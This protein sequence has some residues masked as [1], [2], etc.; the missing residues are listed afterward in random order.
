[1]YSSTPLP[2][3]QWIW[4]RGTIYLL[5]S[6]AGFRYDFDM[7]ELPSKAPF[8]I[9]ADQSY[10]LHINGRYVCRGPVRGIQSNWHFDTVDIL[11]FLKNGHNWISIEAFNPGKSSFFYNHKDAAGLLCSADWDNG[12]QI[13]S[14]V[15][16]WQIFR[17]TAYNNNTAQLS[18]QMGQMEELDLRFDDRSWITEKNYTL[19][20]VMRGTRPTSRKQGS[21]PWTKLS[22]RTIPQLDESCRAPEKLTASGIGICAEHA[23]QAPGIIPCTTADFVD[24][25]LDTIQYDSCPIKTV[26]EKEQMSFTLPAAGKGKFSVAVIDLGATQWLPGVPLFE[27]GEHKAGTILD[28]F[29]NQYMPDGKI[30]Y[31]WDPSEGSQ[32]SLA[33]RVHLNGKTHKFELFQIM[34]VRHIVLVL[35]E[36]A[37]PVDMKLAWRSAVYPLEIKGHFSCSDSVLNAIYDISVHTQRVCALDAFVDTPWREQ[38]QWWGDARVQA[39][40][41]I[42]LSGDSRLLERGI[43]SIAEQKNQLGLTFANA[44]TSDCGPILPDFCLTWVITLHDYWFQTKDTELFK[45]QKSQAESIFNYFENIRG[46]RGLLKYDPRFWLF[47]DWSNLPKSNTPTFLN[48]WYIYAREKY[49]TLLEAAG[50]RSEAEKLNLAISSDKKLVKELLF[51]AEMHLFLPERNAEDKL[52]GAPSVHDQVLALL[53]NIAPEAADSMIEKVIRPCLLGNYS[54]GALPSSFW[55]T[56]LLD[57]AQEYGLRE[58]ALFYIKNNW[59]TMIPAG[60]TWENFPRPNPG[61]LSCAHA[62]SAHI[63]SHLPELVFGLKQLAPRWEDIELDY[64]PL[65][66]VEEAELTLPLPQGE[67]SLRYDGKNVHSQIPQGVHISSRHTR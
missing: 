28:V 46:P 19:P 50:F 35:R 21:L 30:S 18:G 12:T 56:Y 8:I 57:C 49:C 48:L 53:L 41:T 65:P 47:E 25:E 6:Y 62:W 23:L 51:D 9:T 5:N 15:N 38:S 32:V 37:S 17:N 67:L 4:P 22:P 3:A 43:N 55:A 61:E 11:Q 1:M 29:Y 26:T 24:F 34:G 16:D 7:T 58:E 63:I 27:I 64:Q 40:N 44:P 66:G 59:Q 45:K 60:T 10:K 54:A 31:A 39:K 42:F 52:S 2:Q 13:Y 14:N 20:P 36:N 33:S